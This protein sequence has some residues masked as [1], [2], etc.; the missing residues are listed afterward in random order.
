MFS[1]QASSSSGLSS[2]RTCQYEKE[3][4]WRSPLPFRAGGG[5][6]VHLPLATEPLQRPRGQTYN[7]LVL[8]CIKG[9][10]L[11]DVGDVLIIRPPSPTWSCLRAGLT[12]TSVGSIVLRCFYRVQQCLWLYFTHTDTHSGPSHFKGGL[13]IH[14]SENRKKPD[15]R[16]W[17]PPLFFLHLELLIVGLQVFSAR[18]SGLVTQLGVGLFTSPCTQVEV[19][20][21]LGCGL[22]PGAI[23]LYSHPLFT[24]P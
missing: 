3:K 13:E 11:D 4:L 7:I 1:S 6:D 10:S 16:R 12:L 21:A 22:T 19:E 8:P 15:Q 2:A 23:S 9:P 24:A 14:I 17:P 5:Q 18:P 20:K